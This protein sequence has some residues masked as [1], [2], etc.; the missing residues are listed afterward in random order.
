MKA[1]AIISLSLC[2]AL[3]FAFCGCLKPRKKGVP[4]S[5]TTAPATT[6]ATT[7]PTTTKPVVTTS[8][9]VTEPKN[10]DSEYRLDK[11]SHLS[12][13]EKEVYDTILSAL[14]NGE[15]TI[16]ISGDEMN[17]Q[18]FDK[19]FYYYLVVDH[20]EYF[21]VRPF[22]EGYSNGD[23]IVKADF[24]IKYIYSA[25]QIAAKQKKINTIVTALQKKL[26]K[27][28]TNYDKALLVYDYI[29]DNCEYAEEFENADNTAAQQ[30]PVST[31]EGCLLDKRAV[32]TGYSRAYKYILNKMG[33]KCSVVSNPKH[34]WNILML[35][36]EYYY[37]DV[38]WSDTPQTRYKYFAVTT[39]QI[40][41][42][43]DLPEEELPDCTATKNNYNVKNGLT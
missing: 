40:T 16:E 18:I 23:E 2:F 33:I 6:A 3:A 36:D 20:P 32:C 28:A 5:D 35:D 26:P 13:Y 14:E 34:E 22:S 37:T 30:S 24:C 9:P 10:D 8:K 31:I 21:Y 42:D 39:K 12:D 1:K 15:E 19:V 38:T 25:E 29:I 41:E 7:K 11:Y 43:H 17:E 4:Q 27:N